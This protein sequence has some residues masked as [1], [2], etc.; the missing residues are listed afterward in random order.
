MVNVSTLIFIY[1]LLYKFLPIDE[2]LKM[3]SCSFTLIRQV[4][5]TLNLVK[6]EAYVKY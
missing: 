6:I 1:A 3:G 4:F 2:I 5:K